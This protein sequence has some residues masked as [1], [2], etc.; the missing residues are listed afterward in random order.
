[1]ALKTFG[2]RT[3]AALTFGALTLHGLTQA[4]VTPP[5][6]QPAA[7]QSVTSRPHPHR[8]IAVEVS[9]RGATTAEI[10]PVLESVGRICGDCASRAGAVAIR[11]SVADISS[12]GRSLAGIGIGVERV[13]VF[14][15]EE[16]VALAA[17]RFLG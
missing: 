5:A 12:A 11:E 7:A 3:F 15:D 6:I 2:S 9:A 4:P 1:M 16:L 8:Q 14:S 17:W 10:V 13:N